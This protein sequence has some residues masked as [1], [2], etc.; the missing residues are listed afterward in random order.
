M[1]P[2]QN[3]IRVVV[4]DKFRFDSSGLIKKMFEKKLIKEFTKQN[5][6]AFFNEGI[7][8][9]LSLEVRTTSKGSLAEKENQFSTF[10][11]NLSN[12]IKSIINALS[13]AAFYKVNQ[14]AEIS[15]SKLFSNQDRIVIEIE[16]I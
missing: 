11:P 14:V 13:G 9:S 8:L 6:D 7:P 3:K 5:G 12:V 15:V 10:S 16:R 1:Q 2:N 4:F